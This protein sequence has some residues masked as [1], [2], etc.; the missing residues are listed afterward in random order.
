M[1]SDSRGR[2]WINEHYG[3][4]IAV[5]DAASEILT[6][7]DIPTRDPIFGNI[8]NV[9]QLAVD[10][11][12]NIWF[13][14]WTSNKIAVLNTHIPIPFNIE[15]S[16]RSIQINPGGTANI[17]ITLNKD[18]IIDIPV[19]LFASGTLTDTGFLKW[20]EATFEPINLTSE[21]SVSTLTL[22]ANRNIMPG[23]Y[24]LMVGGKY[25]DINRLV[26]VE[27]LVGSPS[28]PSPF[29]ETW[30]LMLLALTPLLAVSLYAIY[31]RFIRRR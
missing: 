19:H 24:T 8:S 5:M 1:V 17:T 18:D 7:Y 20:I 10:H 4:S 26:A 3:N 6:E 11:E 29:F 25:Q 28:R 23:V 12:D 13:T 27:L 2:V 16:Q 15:T 9:L 14:E 31:R 21:R 30:G 22:K